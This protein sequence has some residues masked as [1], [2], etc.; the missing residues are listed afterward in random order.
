[1]LR[2]NILVNNKEVLVITST[3]IT[4]G[5][6]SNDKLNEYNIWVNGENTKRTVYHWRKEGLIKLC[7]MIF[8]EIVSLPELEGVTE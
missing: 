4:K 1:M 3:N 2:M 6:L 7:Y 8:Q 5:G